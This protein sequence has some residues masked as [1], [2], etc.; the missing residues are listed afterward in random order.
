VIVS[1]ISIFVSLRQLEINSKH[2]D[3]QHNS[4][5]A[6]I[7]LEIADRWSEILLIRKKLLKDE[8]LT[9]EQLKADYEENTDETQKKTFKDFLGQPRWENDLRRICNFYETLGVMLEQ[10]SIAPDAMFVLVTVDRYEKIQEVDAAGKPV[11]DATGK[12]VMR[13]ELQ[14]HRRLKGA[15]EYLRKYYRDDIYEYY[16]KYLLE[17]YKKYLKNRALQNRDLAKDARRFVDR[18]MPIRKRRWPR[19]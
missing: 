7:F 4:A 1:M 8:I 5:R 18:A 3:S 13:E 9:F 12:P 19:R 17:A 10:G 11:V 15:I 14:I 6:R 16:D 2:A